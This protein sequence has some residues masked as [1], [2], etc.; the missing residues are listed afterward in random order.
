MVT[1]VMGNS[2]NHLLGCA[3]LWVMLTGC[4]APPVRPIMSGAP[5]R[6]QTG[7]HEVAAAAA[8]ASLNHEEP[9]VLGSIEGAYAPTDQTAVELGITGGGYE[10]GGFTGGF[11]GLR[12]TLPTE[13]RSRRGFYW[14]ME[15]G[16]GGG[17]I[18]DSD[19]HYLGGYGGF[20]ISERWNV[21]TLFSRIRIQAATGRNIDTCLWNTLAVG[22]EFSIGRHTGIF[23]SVAESIHYSGDDYGF[24]TAFELG[25]AVRI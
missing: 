14:D 17:G 19:T 9:V 5:G 22:G 8:F 10:G 7:Q 24:T 6:R 11:T 2:L 3:V 25:L 20:G 15:I 16:L 12:L 18:F 21:F 13:R 4:L 1:V 23:T